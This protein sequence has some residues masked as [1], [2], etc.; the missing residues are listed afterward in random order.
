MNGRAGYKKYLISFLVLLVL[1]AATFFVL[2]DHFEYESIL[3]TIKTADYRFLIVGFVMIPVFLFCQGGVLKLFLDSTGEPTGLLRTFSYACVDFYYSAITPSA[4]GGDPM[5]VY[6]IG[7]DGKA[8]SKGVL[9]ILMHTVLYKT[10]LFLFC[11]LG[12]LFRPEILHMGGKLL[13][14][15]LIIGTAVNGVFLL[16]YLLSMFCSGLVRKLGGGVIA[17]LSAVRIIKNREKTT[18]AFAGAIVEYRDAANHIKKQPLLVLKAFLIVIIQRAA[19]FLV[20]Y[21]V[22]L[23]L[24]YRGLNPLY[25][26]A[27]QAIIALSVD[28]LPLPG[29]VGANELAMILMYDSIF[30]SSMAASAMIMTRGINYYFCLLLT[31]I[32]SITKYILLVLRRRRAERR[33]IQQ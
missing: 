10:T 11:A 7:K 22:Y 25:F 24:G 21:F 23:S 19:F 9:A 32:A 6:H 1:I 28:S 29:G 12:L 2:F 33:H 17:L 4:T 18:V 30:G 13:K 3:E 14:V 5:V 20:P 15:L 27:I 31:G 26:I 8:V 16:I